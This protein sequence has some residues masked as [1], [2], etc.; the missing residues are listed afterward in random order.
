M[1]E[2]SLVFQEGCCCMGID[3]C[4]LAYQPFS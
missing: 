1:G 3:S 4:W 2:E